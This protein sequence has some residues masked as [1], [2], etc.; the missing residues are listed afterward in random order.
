MKLEGRL[1]PMNS[2][3]ATST[4]FVGEC[5]ELGGKPFDCSNS[6]LADK[7][8]ETLWA[9]IGH[10][11]KKYSHCRDTALCLQ[12]LELQKIPEPK[13]IMGKKINE[14]TATDM[15]GLSVV[16]KHMASKKIDQ[17]IKKEETCASNLSIAY[18]IMWGQCPESTKQKVRMSANFTTIESASTIIQLF[19]LIREV[20]FNF[21]H[22]K[23]PY[24]AI[25]KAHRRFDGLYQSKEMT[26]PAFLDRYNAAYNGVVSFGDTIGV[27]E[28]KG[29]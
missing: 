6:S 23:D 9:I 20:A 25:Y 26:N 17:Y 4:R 1:V 22:N 3:R 27:D 11:D 21:E 5:K 13:I 19:I 28:R 15:G 29:R 7:F 12:Y 18:A 10:V 16:R 24:Q 14:I 2:A 8:E